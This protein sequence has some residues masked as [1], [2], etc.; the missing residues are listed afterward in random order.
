VKRSERRR[1]R[2]A[3]AEMEVLARHPSAAVRDQAE[4]AIVYA[5]LAEQRDPRPS[6]WL[7]VR[8]WLA[9]VRDAW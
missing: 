6:W 9:G 3:V 2:R 5:A 8:L 7:S 4:R 1:L